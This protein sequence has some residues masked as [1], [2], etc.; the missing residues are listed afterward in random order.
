MKYSSQ[1]SKA[2]NWADDQHDKNEIRIQHPYQ[3]TFKLYADDGYKKPD[4][5]NNGQGGSDVI[6]GRCL[7]IEG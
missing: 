2:E 4:A 6:L 5:G 3:N 1:F 7:C